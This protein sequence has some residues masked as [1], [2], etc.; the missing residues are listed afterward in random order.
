MDWYLIKTATGRERVVRDRID[1]L[2]AREGMDDIE[3][4]LVP[5]RSESTGTGKSRRTVDKPAFPGYVLI[6]MD[7]HDSNWET[8]RRVMDVMGFVGYDSDEYDMPVPQA[9]PEQEVMQ[10]LGEAHIDTAML[11][12]QIG[13]TVRIKEGPFEDV[14]GRIGDTDGRAGKV[15]VDVSVFGRMTPIETPVANIERI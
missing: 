13:D 5:T 3:E 4:V 10:Y 6:R 15:T 14:I 2:K 1:R 7:M 12:I 9:I 8:V 11:N